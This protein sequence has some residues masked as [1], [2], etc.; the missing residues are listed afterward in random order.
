M[1]RGIIENLKELSVGEE[2]EVSVN[3]RVR[4]EKERIY[5]RGVWSARG[6]GGCNG[7][8]GQYIQ[9]KR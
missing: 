6:D 9:S 5:R 1:V 2:M 3:R 8:W 7:C 4:A